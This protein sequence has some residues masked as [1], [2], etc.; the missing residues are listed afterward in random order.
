MDERHSGDEQQRAPEGDRGREGFG[1]DGGTRVGR[2]DPAQ[3]A[4]S[5]TGPSSM[6]AQEG[7]EG[8]IFDDTEDAHGRG[9]VPPSETEP[10]WSRESQHGNPTGAGA[11]A[12]EGTHNAMRD[13]APSE[14][15][16]ADAAADQLGDKSDQHRGS[17][18][19]SGR[20][21]EHVSGYGGAGGQPKRSSD[22]RE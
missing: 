16:G 13:R 18:P 1:D 17:E 19:L 2:P 12:A 3:N 10:R 15:T 9:H 22:Q 4:D 8:S 21:S 5:H 7:L 14:N 6:P 11:E 20:T